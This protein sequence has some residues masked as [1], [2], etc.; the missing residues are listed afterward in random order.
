M[1]W[2]ASRS[3]A[4]R[5]M[6]LPLLACVAMVVGVSLLLPAPLG[7]QTEPRLGAPPAPS[8]AEAG[9]AA[10]LE[11]VRDEPLLLRA[12]LQAMPKGGDLH[13]H[14]SGAEY[15][16]SF[17]AYAAEDG[18]C[19]A[20]TT[21]ALVPPPCDATE[22]RQPASAALSN[23]TLYDALVDAWSMRDFVPTPGHSGHDQFFGTFDRFGEAWDRRT[24]DVLADIV[25]RA[26]AENVQYLE[27]MFGLDRGAVGALGARLGW[28]DELGRL[29]GRLL[30]EDVAAI[31]GATRERLDAAEARVR[32][33]LRCGTPEADRGCHV[34][35][36]YLQTGTRVLPPERV[37]AQL[38][39]GF[40]LVRAD[41]RVVGVNLVAPEDAYVARRDYR[42][43]M[44]MLDYLH[45]YAPEVPIALHAG[46]LTL[47]LVPPEDLR[48]HVREAVERG[49]ARRIGHGAAVMYED[50][51]FE[52][53]DELR[54]R[55][56]L[57]EILLVS[58]AQILGVTG[59]HSP[60]P[61]YLQWRVPVALAT[62]DMGVSRSDMTAQYQ[63][64]VESYGL[65][66]G[67]LKHMAR[68]SLEYSFLPGPSLW[69]DVASARHVPACAGEPPADYQIHGA[70]CR[71]FVERSERAAAQWRLEVDFARFE[72]RFA[73]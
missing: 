5:A 17:I 54:R 29:H 33:R 56:V 28:E 11:R 67:T 43:H 27:L 69:D 22:G 68:N 57:V 31:V 6:A 7:A 53:L 58:N 62:D 42:L 12:F 23:Q 73:S 52:L 3:A 45:G 39:V 64:A 55:N 34:V 72:Q 24:G 4:R 16:E 50:A 20:P 60:L 41:P 18:L 63:L 71:D 65:A 8:A 70:G 9:T 44:A 14:P 38:A 30:A 51:P 21:L 61:I 36:R 46:E 1:S 37:F 59:R 40:E 47:G 25:A 10:Y 19:V 26:A 15:A 35:V 13:N 32:E 49:H 66:Y 2:D 48:F